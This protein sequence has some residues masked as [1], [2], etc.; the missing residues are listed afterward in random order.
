MAETRRIVILFH[1]DERPERLHQYRIWHCVPHW[2]AAGF[3]VAMQF[4]VAT[5]FDADIVIP[6]IDLS[7]MPDEYRRALDTYPCVLNRGVGDIR[8]TTFSRNL[9]C[10]QDSYGGP[11][12]VK[13][14]ANFGGAPERRLARRQPWP[15]RTAE[16]LAGARRRLRRIAA[17]G[18]T[19]PL[20]YAEGL[21]PGAYPIFPHKRDVP[22]AVFENADLVVERFR[23]EHMGGHYH[24]RSYAFLGDRSVT[25]RTTADDPVVKGA[26]G[27]KPEVVCIDERIVAERAA[28]GFD[29]GKFDYVLHDGE[30]VLLD[31]NVTPSF[32]RVYPP[33]LREHIAREL[34]AGIGA[35]IPVAT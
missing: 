16:L 13:T 11:V 30:A 19:N 17:T 31:V 27:R 23:P 9:V 15:Q 12:I 2:R 26:I 6:Q 20:A 5:P 18:S 3:D 7:V 10:K 14:N 35:C 32:G 21:D 4:G 33:E 1:A 8:K 34:A 22:A 24:L 28:L 25:V 29:Y